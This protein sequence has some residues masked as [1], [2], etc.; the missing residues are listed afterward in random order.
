MPA[1][2]TWFTC[3]RPNLNFEVLTEVDW[4]SINSCPS[5]KGLD[6]VEQI[7]DKEV[8]RQ[9]TVSIAEIQID[10]LDV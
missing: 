9:G 10:F 3:R 5:S 8:V 2:E 1:G 7:I 4:N 6:L